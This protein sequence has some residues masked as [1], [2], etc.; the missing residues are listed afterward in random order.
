[1]RSFKD[2]NPVVSFSKRKLKHKP[3]IFLLEFDVGYRH[4]YK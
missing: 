3:T 1:M 4:S 2:S